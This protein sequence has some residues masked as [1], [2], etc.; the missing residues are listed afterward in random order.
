MADASVA[1]ALLHDAQ[2]TKG[3]DPDV[4][5]QTGTGDAGQWSAWILDTSERY[6]YRARYISYEA[7][8]SFIPNG[9]NSLVP[10]DQG[11]FIHYDFVGTKELVREHSSL[12]SHQHPFTDTSTA[13]LST[14]QTPRYHCVPN[15]EEEGGS[16]DGK[17]SVT[18]GLQGSGKDG[19][20]LM[21]AYPKPAKE[22]SVLLNKKARKRLQAEKRKHVSSRAKVDKWLNN[23]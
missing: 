12:S 1:Q 18:G 2:E 13:S 9:R 8:S 20:R 5:T 17:P 14:S 23:T 16:T 21:M 4:I 10:D 11:G 7:A 22:H 15:Y 19:K 6:Y 3:P